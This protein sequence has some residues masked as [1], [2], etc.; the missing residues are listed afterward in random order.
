MT[1][2]WK[3]DRI[4]VKATATAKAKAK[5]IKEMIENDYSKKRLR[6]TQNMHPFGIKIC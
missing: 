1:V 2:T 6:L 3:D 4:T 5:A